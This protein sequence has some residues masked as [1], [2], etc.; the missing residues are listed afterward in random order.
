MTDPAAA[1]PLTLLGSVREIGDGELQE[2]YGYPDAPQRV[3]VRANFI[4]SLDGGASVDGTTGALGGAGDRALFN[5][6][7]T[8]ADVIV[9]GAGTVRAESYGGARLS[10]RERRHRQARGQT[11]VP[12]LAIV[13]GSGRLDHDLPVFTHTEV[14]PLVLTCAAAADEIRDRLSGLADVVDCSGD[15]AARVDPSGLLAALAAR[16]LSR[17][18]TEGGPT[19][20]STLVDDDLLD[21]LCLTI[22]PCLVGGTG[23]RITSGPGQV[24]TRMRCAHILTDESGYVYTRYVRSRPSAA[25]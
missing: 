18:L 25:R 7:R 12:Q 8:L 20:L 4:T 1:T 21:E 16:G 17:V 9:V 6:L 11:E 22:A 15:E 10:A 5:L 23:P 3:W 14:P 13:T 19:L 24:L 2:I